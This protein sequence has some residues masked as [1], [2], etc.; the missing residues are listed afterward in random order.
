MRA[1]PVL[2]AGL[3]AGVLAGG[4]VGVIV[5]ATTVPQLHA[6]VEK[7][8][9]MRYATTAKCLT[10]EKL[11]T[12][13]V[14]GLP[15]A[16]GKNGAAGATGPAGPTGATGATGPAGTGGDAGGYYLADGSTVQQVDNGPTMVT[17]TVKLPAGGYIITFYGTVKAGMSGNLGNPP[18]A[19]HCSIDTSPSGDTTAGLANVPILTTGSGTFFSVQTA[20]QITSQTTYYGLCRT[21]GT[22]LSTVVAMGHL[23]ATAAVR[24]PNIP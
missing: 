15:G 16:A 7:N 9:T 4:A 12:W 5:G 23:L 17:A 2:V 14:Q 11:L 22:G 10:G 8:G 24:L 20:V 1:L 21:T 3:V 6:C 13:N 18:V 19:G